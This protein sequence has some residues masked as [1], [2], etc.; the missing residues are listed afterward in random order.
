MD[1]AFRTNDEAK[2]GGACVY[3]E[4]ERHEIA[5]EAVHLSLYLHRAHAWE[6]KGEAAGMR[7]NVVNAKRSS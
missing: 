5:W 6:V 4:V 3:D 2:R 7:L 1:R